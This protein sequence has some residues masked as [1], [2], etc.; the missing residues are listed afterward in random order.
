VRTRRKARE[1]REGFGS[2]ELY[3]VRIQRASPPPQSCCWLPLQGML[4]DELR[5]AV[6]MLTVDELE[7][8]HSAGRRRSKVEVSRGTV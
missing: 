5:A 6:A 1:G 7:Q 4:H 2:V 8:K 3:L